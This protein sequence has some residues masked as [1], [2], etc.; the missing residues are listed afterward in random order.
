MNLNT[1]PRLNKCR[2]ILA[3]V[4]A[5]GTSTYSTAQPLTNLRMD[6]FISVG[7]GQITNEDVPIAGYDT[8]PSFSA[9]TIVG[10]QFSAD[11]NDKTDA[12]IQLVS[13]GSETF[14]TEAAWAYLNYQ[15]DPDTNIRFGRL[16]TPHFYYSDFLEVG[17]AY[18]WIRPPTDVYRFDLVSSLN[19][20]DITRRFKFDQYVGYVQAFYGRIKRPFEIQSTNYELELKDFLGVIAG[21]EWKGL[22]S[23]VSAQQ[24]DVFF[25]VD[26]DA[27]CP[28]GQLDNVNN[29]DQFI[30]CLNLFS[31]SDRF[32]PDGGYARFYDA[33]FTWSH[34]NF[35]AITEYNVID[36]EDALFLDNHAFMVGITYQLEQWTPHLTYT[37][38][39]D[40]EDSEANVARTQQLFKSEVSSVIAGARFDYAENAAIKFEVQQRQR[41]T[42]N[43][44]D[45]GLLYSVAIDAIF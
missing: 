7:A 19:G 5:L 11:I 20:V 17:Y 14:N 9:D 40:E 43:D 16:R 26:Q 18:H 8:R 28:N 10:L 24:V 45:T 23:R 21:V 4:V 37:Q 29:V 38:R 33:A 3:L 12:T 34:N 31:G 35:G 6:G 36:Y 32:T 22:T 42:E 2:W 44:S 27:T 30:A 13:R 15:L 1:K 41:V 39:I 25:D